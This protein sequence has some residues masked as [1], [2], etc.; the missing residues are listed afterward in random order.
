MTGM[1]LAVVEVGMFACSMVALAQQTKPATAPTIAL[2]M[3]T[4][5]TVMETQIV[6]AAQA[7]PADKYSFAPSDGE[8]RGSRTFGL[9][10][11]H[12]AAV[13]FAL[14]S[15]ILG[16][17]PP[18]GVSLQGATNGPDDLQTKD[19]IVNYLQKSFALGHK[20]LATIT[21][22]NAV[23]PITYPPLPFTQPYFSTRLGLAS[24]ACTHASDHYGQMAVY[25]RMNGVVPPASQGQTPAN[26]TPSKTPGR[27]NGDAQR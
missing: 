25:L 2:A 23:T 20:A 27:A 14:Y 10:V 16:E 3:D 9:E 18:P 12:V 6:P 1:R 5:L 22:E 4:Q 26:S 11:R 15:A 7:M 19:Q 8:F 21:A 13:N 17:L 24:F